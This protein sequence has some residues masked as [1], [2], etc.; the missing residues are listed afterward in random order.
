MAFFNPNRVDF[1]YNT[2]MIDAVG[3]VGRSLWD[4]YKENVA[5]NQNQMKI[6]ETMRSNL[7]SEALI[8]AKNDETA[9]HN[10]ATEAETAS[11]N[12]FTQNFKQNELTEKVKNWNNLATHYANQDRIGAMNANTMAYNAD[13][14]RMNA[15]TSARRLDFDKNKHQSD[16]YS[17]SLKTDLGFQALGLELP[18]NLKNASPEQQYRYKKAMVDINTPNGNVYGAIK[19]GTKMSGLLDRNKL[20]QKYVKDIADMTSTLQALQRAKETYTGGEVGWLDNALHGAAKVFDIQDKKTSDFKKELSNA[21]L[22]FKN[23]FGSGKMSNMQYEQL[24]K[25]FPTGDEIS[26]TDFESAMD[27]TANQIRTFYQN[28]VAEMQNGGVNMEQ[29]KESLPVL[30]EMID[31]LYF[32]RPR[33]ANGGM[34]VKQGRNDY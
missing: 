29:F 8:G 17:D 34:I 13:T 30:N 4:I 9:R 20:Q 21:T 18:E 32:T 23:A 19:D 24:L 22:L 1:N 16:L 25:A 14:S 33:G 5:K 15:N 7:A 27:A 10:L 2:N 3:A 11:N 31:T 26:N 6:N 12:A 28:L